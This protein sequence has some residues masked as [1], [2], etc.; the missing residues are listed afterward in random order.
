MRRDFNQSGLAGDD[1]RQIDVSFEKPR[2]K[3]VRSSF[4]VNGNDF[5]Q[6]RC[7]LIREPF[8]IA[9]RRE[10]DHTHAS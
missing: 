9:A 6:M 2:A 8:D 3:I 1:P 10:S 7:D 4:A 5:R